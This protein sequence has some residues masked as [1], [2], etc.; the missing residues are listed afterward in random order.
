MSTAIKFLFNAIFK[1][2]LAVFLPIPG[3]DNNVFI[4]IG[5]TLLYT[6]DKILQAYIINIVF[7]LNKPI[8]RIIFLSLFKPNLSISVELDTF[9]N[10]F[11]VTL[12]T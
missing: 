11:L 12:L 8:V 6:F 7:L 1:N 10:N 4:F 5:I 3:K 9:K 2:K